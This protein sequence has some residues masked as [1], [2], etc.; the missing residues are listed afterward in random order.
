M[1]LNNKIAAFATTTLLAEYA[2]AANNQAV[3][4]ILGDPK[5][6]MAV[7]LGFGLFSVLKTF[8]FFQNIQKNESVVQSLLLLGI[9]WY[10]TFNWTTV[11][12]WFGIQV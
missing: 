4:E 3:S 1:K 8:E 12:G 11:I 2:A 9:L 10:L 6:Q 5:V 7:T